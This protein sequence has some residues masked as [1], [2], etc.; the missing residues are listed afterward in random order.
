MGVDVHHVNGTTKTYPDA[1]LASNSDGFFRIRKW[2]P[3]IRKH[4]DIELLSARE[5]I[6]A[7]VFSRRGVLQSIV[8]GAG[9]RH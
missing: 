4:E 9:K 8:N 5:V 7:E 6:F 2:N 3:K 1:D